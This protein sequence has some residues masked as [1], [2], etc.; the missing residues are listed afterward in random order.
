MNIKKLQL[1]LKKENEENN[2]EENNIYKEYENYIKD[3]LVDEKV[4]MMDNY[5]HHYSTTCLEHC[6]NVSFCSYIICKKLGLDYISAARGGLLHDLFLYDWRTTKLDEGKHAFR[7]P[8]IALEN[9]IKICELNP[10]EKDIIKKHMWP[11]TIKT[12]KY[13]ES[14]IV[15]FADKYCALMEFGQEMVMN[16]KQSN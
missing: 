10:I 12:P 5:R 13:I 7:H 15:S 2:L 4:R 3:L 1:N 6:L 8:D 9:A 16:I 11:L 14:F